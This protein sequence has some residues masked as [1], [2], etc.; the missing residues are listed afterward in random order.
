MFAH[1]VVGFSTRV[2]PSGHGGHVIGGGVGGG[3]GGGVGGGGGGGGEV[4]RVFRGA[5]VGGAG[6]WQ[7]KI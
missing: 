6:I 2:V 4:G 3:G 7:A 1:T 5:G